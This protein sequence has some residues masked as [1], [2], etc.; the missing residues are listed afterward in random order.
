MCIVYLLSIVCLVLII[1]LLSIVRLLT[2]VRLLSVV[3]LGIVARHLAL[4]IPVMLTIPS[5][6]IDFN[7]LRLGNTTPR[8]W[9]CLCNWFSHCLRLWLRLCIFAD[10]Y[11]PELP[12]SNSHSLFIVLK[13]TPISP[14]KHLLVHQILMLLAQTLIPLD[15]SFL[16]ALE[17]TFLIANF[18]HSISQT[19]KK[20]VSKPSHGLSGSL[21]SFS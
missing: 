8:H 11:I 3:R 14:K 4:G 13:P 6:R 21:L 19:K 9:L 20:K 17:Q 15:T 5:I 1:G 10:T 2:I 12:V 18:L 7:G 16:F